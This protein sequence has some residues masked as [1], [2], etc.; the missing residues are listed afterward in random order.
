MFTDDELRQISAPTLLL[1]GEQDVVYDLNA[2]RKRAARLPAN[3]HIEVIPNAGH[4]LDYD[5]PEAVS[6]RVVEFIRD[7]T[8]LV[9]KPN[10]QWDTPIAGGEQGS[11]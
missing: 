10:V 3:F 6:A 1:Y 2:I 7:G 5:Q 8:Q 4:V 11:E 9:E